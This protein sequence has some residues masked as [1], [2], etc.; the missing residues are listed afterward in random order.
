MSHEAAAP[1]RTRWSQLSLTRAG[2]TP[3]FHSLVSRRRLTTEL[4]GV[5]CRVLPP[6]RVTDVQRLGFYLDV[7]PNTGAP[8]ANIDP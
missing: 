5:G 6:A 8:L 3:R 4:R 2:Q 1:N 7:F